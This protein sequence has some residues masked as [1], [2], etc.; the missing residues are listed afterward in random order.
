MAKIT[1]MYH[2]GLAA[3]DPASLAEFYRDTI[4]LAITGGSGADNPFG[5][6]AFLSSRHQAE[7]H[8]LVLFAN[9][10]LAHVA[11]R[12]ATLADLRAFYRQITERGIPIKRAVNHGT[13]LAFYFDDPEGNMI[14][15]YWST[16][17]RNWQ[18]Y[19]DPIDLRAPEDELMREVARVA[20]Q[21]GLSLPTAAP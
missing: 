5:A 12:V 15:I 4:G 17:V 11:F 8:E 3:R 2:V 21:A 13:S 16:D 10:A 1:G 19:A 18:P 9:P 20:A 7:D 6:S 14:E